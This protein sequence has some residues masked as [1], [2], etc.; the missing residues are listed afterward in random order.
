MIDFEKDAM[1]N[2]LRKNGLGL[3]AIVISVGTWL[4]FWLRF[5][6]FTWDSFGAMAAT[7]G[8]IVAFL[9][10]FQIWA[11]I[12][13][14]RF[15]E[16]IVEEQK[17]LDKKI[18]LLELKQLDADYTYNFYLAQVYGKS[19]DLPKYISFTL[20]AIYYGLMCNTEQ[21][22]IGCNILIKN[23]NNVVNI[24][25]GL[26]LTKS[27][28]DDLLYS[29]YKIENVKNIKKLNKDGLKNIGNSLRE[30]NIID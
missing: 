3:L 18:K 5:S 1:K 2:F 14:G 17:E 8:I 10:G 20:Q 30:A 23:V 11:V 7:M 16:R 19:L 9:T 25:Q 21:H 29:F 12:D 15:E 6:P 24:K 13:K 26:S 22:I 27:E 4:S 28:Q